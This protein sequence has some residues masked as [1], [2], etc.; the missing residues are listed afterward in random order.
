MIRPYL[1]LGLV[2]DSQQSILRLVQEGKGERAVVV[3]QH[4]ASSEQSRRH[5]W[6]HRNK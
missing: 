2:Q 4:A 5:R 6:E 1:A 3:L